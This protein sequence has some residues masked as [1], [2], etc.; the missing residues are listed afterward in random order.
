MSV[1]QLSN[2]GSMIVRSQKIK[3]ALLTA[4]ADEEM[5]NIMNCVMHHSKSIKDIILEN[6]GISH[7]SA[8][9]KIKWLLDEGLLI[10]DKIVITSAGKKFSLYHSTLK[11]IHVR[12]EDNN[13]IVEAEQNSDVAKKRIENFFSLD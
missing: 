5:V 9:R 12:Y 2:F 3:R 7:T 4:L 8:Y 6:N 10:V 1:Q 13:V 11:A